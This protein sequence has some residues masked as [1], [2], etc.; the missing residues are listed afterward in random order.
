MKK[1]HVLLLLA[2]CVAI[3][4]PAYCQTRNANPQAVGLEVLIPDTAAFAFDKPNRANWEPYADALGDDSL[5][6]TAG[7]YDSNGTD[8]T[9]RPGVVIIRPDGTFGEY[10]G[11][12]GDN[13]SPYTANVDTI[14]QDGNPPQ[15]AGDHRAG[16]VRYIVGTEST[17]YNFDAFKSDGR[18]KNTY[19]DHAYCVQAFTLTANGPQKLFNCMDPI[20]GGSTGKNVGKLRSGGVAC[21]SN[22]NWV[23]V[24]E[25]RTALTSATSKAPVLSILNGTT[26][27]IVKGPFIC[28]E[29]PNSDGWDGLTSFDGGFAIR[30]NQPTVKIFFYDNAGNLTATWDQVS[31]HFEYEGTN[32]DNPFL[33]FASNPDGYTTTIDQGGR[34]DGCHIAGSITGKYIYYANRGTDY[35]SFGAGK[36][37]YVVK[38]DATTGASVKE[39]LVTESDMLGDEYYNIP[40]PDRT[41]CFC[42]SNG[43]VVVTWVDKANSGFNQQVARIFN[44]DLEPVTET[45]LVFQ[46]SEIG[47]GSDPAGETLGVTDAYGQVA[48]SDWGILFTSRVASDNFFPKNADEDYPQ[49]THL[50]TVVKN[51]LS[52]TVDD[53]QLF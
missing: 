40:N 18:W 23:V 20:Y 1:I 26:G 5:I 36:N 45:F 10:A 7:T 6:L 12:Y 16:Q 9:E 53:W 14:R 32:P 41:S 4:T 44:S 51:P 15:I 24:A 17:P 34:G 28:P 8:S 11:F 50:F 21:L 49:N 46:A 42:D 38:I 52:V 3:A 35:E 29:D 25:D 47:F 37:V 2:V 19:S 39:R 31:Y 33:D 48:M 43:N 27:A 13:G 22:G 30:V